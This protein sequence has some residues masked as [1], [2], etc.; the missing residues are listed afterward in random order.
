MA[1]LGL[2]VPWITPE[3]LVLMDRSRESVSLWARP[4]EYPSQPALQILGLYRLTSSAPPSSRDLSHVPSIKKLRK[5]ILSGALLLCAASIGLRALLELLYFDSPRQADP[6]S[7]RTGPYVVKNVVIYITENL[8]DVLYWLR[9][10]FYFF[11]ALIV[12]SV[13][14]DQ[15][16]PSRRC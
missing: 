13:I 6:L 7:G 9:W 15:I 2:G 12:I 1:E 3:D 4:L 11:G 5:I 14:L 8:S 10:S 16:W